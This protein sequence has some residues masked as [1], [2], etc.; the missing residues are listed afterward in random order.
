MK[1]FAFQP[2]GHGPASFF[3]MAKSIEGARVRVHDFCQNQDD[4]YYYA[5]YIGNDNY[6]VLEYD[7]NIIV[8][9]DNS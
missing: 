4:E 5:Y 1:L 3:I 2:R 9:N 7:E 6:E 8:V